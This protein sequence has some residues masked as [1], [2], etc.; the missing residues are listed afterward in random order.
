MV[1]SV[2]WYLFQ[3]LLSSI[4]CILLKTRIENIKF[5]CHNCIIY[6]KL[7]SAK[8]SIFKT[9]FEAFRYMLILQLI[10]SIVC[11]LFTMMFVSCTFS[12]DQVSF[13]FCERRVGWDWSLILWTH[14]PSMLWHCWLGLLTRKTRLRYKRNFSRLSSRNVHFLR[15]TAI[16]R[17]YLA[18]TPLPRLRSHVRCLSSAHW[19]ARVWLPIGD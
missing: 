10:C 7:N 12:R 11:I 5:Q 6:M 8:L 3:N 9:C 17:F 18:P 16:L 1:L 2:A 15:T 4:K 13:S 19:E 14:H